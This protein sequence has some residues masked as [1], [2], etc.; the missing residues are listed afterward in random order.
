M[1]LIVLALAVAF[2]LAIRPAIRNDNLTALENLDDEAL[3]VQAA[4]AWERKVWS[5]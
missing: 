2:G 3:A 4:E 1:I 5:A